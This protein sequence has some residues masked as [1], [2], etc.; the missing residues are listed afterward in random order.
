LQTVGMAPGGPIC[1]PSDKAVNR[2]GP[3]LPV[4]AYARSRMFATDFAYHCPP[5]AVATPR[6][7]KADAI[8]LSVAAPAFFAS[9]MMGNTL[10]ANLS[11]SRS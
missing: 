8:S 2:E 3:K 4:V 7:F 10:A 1:P 11:A 6:A 9:R 5:R